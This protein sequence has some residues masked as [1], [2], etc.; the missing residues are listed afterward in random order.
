MFRAALWGTFGG[1]FLLVTIRAQTGHPPQ[2]AAFEK[3]ASTVKVRWD[4]DYLY[5]EGNGM[6]RHGMMT[7]I[8]SWQQQVPIP[9]DYRGANA[10]R[11]PLRPV[12]ANEPRMLRNQFLR[13]AVAVAVNGVPIFNPQN[14]R[15]DISAEIGELDRWGG[16]CGRADDYHYHVVPLHLESVAGQG[17]PLA[18]ALDGYPI[19]GLREA[20]GKLPVQLDALNGHES[21]GVG[22]HYHASERYPYVNGGFH[23]VVMERDGQVDPQPSAR[24]VRPSLT[25]LRGAVITGFDEVGEKRFRLD[26]TL[27]G[28]RRSVQYEVGADG[29][30]EFEFRDGRGGVRKESYSQREG[31]ARGRGPGGEGGKGGKREVGGDRSAADAGPRKGWFEVHGLELDP[32]GDGFIPWKE[33]ELEVRRVFASFDHDGDGVVTPEESK[34]RTGYRS[35]LSGFLGEHFGAMDTNGDGL[36]Q[37]AEFTREVVRMFEKQ[38]RDRDGV[39]SAR[40]W[41]DGASMPTPQK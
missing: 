31:G 26:F 15:G 40:E 37:S 1:F 36:L 34:R 29:K 11:I 38:D 18:F 3:F 10:W 27:S 30:V 25:A 4:A 13:G 20:D 32:D 21:A 35:P 17:M 33:V 41:R 22:Y 16:H 8:S 5:L 24:P 23:G 6:P 14:N 28:E 12:P 2:A 9:Q 19:Y 7:G 39:L